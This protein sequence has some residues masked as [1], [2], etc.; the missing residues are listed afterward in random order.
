M[1]ILKL[2]FLSNEEEPLT[3]D[4]DLLKTLVKE[5]SYASTNEKRPILTGV[6]IKFNNNNLQAV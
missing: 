2:I 1:I 5:T 6:N 3:I 4:A